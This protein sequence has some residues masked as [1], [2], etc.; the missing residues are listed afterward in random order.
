MRTKERILTLTLVLI[1]LVSLMGCMASEQNT[2]AVEALTS[3]STSAHDTE[4]TETVSVSENS[5]S[6]E[7]IVVPTEVDEISTTVPTESI[8]ETESA[9]GLDQTQKNSVAMLNFLSLIAQE[10]NYYENGRLY[11]DTAYS[12]LVSNVKPEMVDTLT[13]DQINGLLDTITENKLVGLKYD[14]LNVLYERNKGQRIWSE[15]ASSMKNSN[16]ISGGNLVE[17]CTDAGSTIID[18]VGNYMLNTSEIEYLLEGCELGDEAIKQLHECR[19]ELFNYR[20]QIIRDNNLPSSLSVND[21][22]IEEFVEWEHKTNVSQKIQYFESEKETYKDF[23]PYWLELTKCYYENGEYEKCLNA[24]AEYENM[25]MDIFSKDY[26]YARALPSAIIAAS[27]VMDES[28][29]FVYAED[30]L[31]DLQDNIE[32]TDWD[33]HFFIAETYVD[34]YIKTGNRDYLQKAFDIEL[35]NVNILAEGQK[36][37]NKLYLQD[38]VVFLATGNETSEVE[39]L[40]KKYNEELEEERK[41]ELPPV[42]EPLLVNCELLFSLAKE[43]NVEQTT[44][45]KIEQFLT[46]SGES[47]FLNEYLRQKYTFSYQMPTC[48]A[49]FSKDEL[50]V[51]ARFMSDSSGV[52]VS[53]IDD[54]TVN[55]Y[56]DW[57]I[58]SVDRNNGTFNDFTVSLTSDDIDDQEWSE[59]AR[60]TVI[61]YDTD[62]N[63]TIV[64]M[65]F[66]VE[67]YTDYWIF[68]TTIEFKQVQ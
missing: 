2:G 38:T 41:K 51:P 56:D 22:A 44:K 18:F 29:Y 52:R 39:K 46:E 3:S 25:E 5:T 65:V 17:I 53:V 26:L 11:L 13:Q 59:N 35:N 42:Y 57:T 31:N 8:S 1:L 61:I 47:V 9:A 4:S 66:E 20:V 30:V 34:L 63:E 14:R 54:G 28:Q 7:Q 6:S 62:T 32:R 15:M 60:V 64:T 40:R 36:K 27:H 43:L 16:G 12:M 49:E 45:N 19:K 21:K 68:G 23:G 48:N 37:L 10:I 58:Q 67:D 55:T 24:L 33:L 50:I